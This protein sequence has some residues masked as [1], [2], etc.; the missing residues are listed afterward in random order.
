MLGPTLRSRLIAGT[1]PAYALAL[2]AG[3]ISVTA[4]A[5]FGAFWVLPLTLAVLF[6]LADSR[7]VRRAA[8]IGLAFGIGQFGAGTYWILIALS[9]V[10]GAPLPLAVGLL[11]GLIVLLAAF[12]ALSLGVAARIAP[13]P[14]ALRYLIWL[15]ILWTLVE[16]LRSWV[17]SGFPWLS[18]GYSQI[19]SPLVGIVPI[20]GVFGASWAVALSAGALAWASTQPRRAPWAIALLIVLW[21]GAFGL[22]HVHWTTPNSKP[23]SVTLVQGDIAQQAKW[24]P[25]SV[26]QAI[27]RYGDLTRGH[28]QSDLVIWPE[29]AIPDYYRSVKP[30]LEN[31]GKRLAKHDTTLITGLLR[32]SDDGQHIY[33]SVVAVGAGNGLYA[34]RHLVPFG[35]YF[36]VPEIVRRWMAESGMPYSD[37]TPGA[38][39]QKPIVA[40]QLALGISI[41]Y[42]D[43][44]GDLIA[45]DVPP[46][47][48]L[49]N[50]SDDAWFGRSIG[51]D[52]HFE[53]ARMRA[54]ETGRYLLRADNSAV[55]GI[56]APSGVV[57]ARA[58]DFKSTALTG[59]FRSYT[60]LTPFAHWGNDGVVVLALAIGGLAALGQWLRSRRRR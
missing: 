40:G 44:F 33:N 45:S 17:F 24:S 35:E 29:T 49:V 12:I 1:W 22:R 56:V 25:E 43:I 32:A 2:I 52:Q 31:L 6:R 27:Y 51:P 48:V 53:I 34:K 19:A 46:A 23:L 4:F 15:P 30:A 38:A 59:H 50:V 47:N 10:G 13:H 39:H 28:W 20:L 3:M 58:P 18:A 8:A 36:P 14:G 16:W 7:T 11:L 37:L 26:N 60:G 57:V 9:G 55:T 5:P 42:E 41:C 21:T 54:V